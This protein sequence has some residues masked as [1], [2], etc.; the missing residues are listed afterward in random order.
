MI[1]SEFVRS[2]FPA[3]QNDFVFMDNAGGA[4][5]PRQVIERITEYLSHYNVQ[6]GASYEVSAVSGQK[7][8]AVTQG[9][10]K[11]INA[12]RQEE[13]VVGPSTTLLLRILS[14]CLSRQWK[15]GDEVIVT[16]SDHEANV[17][18]WTDL[19]EQG[20]IIKIW[21]LNPDTLTFELDDL[22]KLIT[23]RTRLV[24]MVHASNILGTINPIREFADF[25]HE[26]GAL[27]CVDGVAYA[28]HRQID[29][30]AL[31]VDFYVY[32]CYK[33]FG[34]H[35][36]V[37]YGRYELLRGLDGLNHYFIGKDQVPYKLQPGNFN[38]ELTYGLQGTLDY[39]DALQ[40]H[41]FPGVAEDQFSKVFELIAAHE[42]ILAE[43]LISYLRTLPAV[44]IIGME[45]SNR[46]TRVATISFVHANLKSSDI[47]KKVDPH[48]IGIRYGDFYAKKLIHDLGLD[49]DEG[50]VRVSLVHYNTLQ[51]VEQLIQ[52]FREIL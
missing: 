43:H 2:Q 17:S 40:K 12:S 16:N 18:C 21:K 37:L 32:S 33:V 35:L 51:E 36:A 20:I 5:V 10:A 41:H 15:P 7:L 11:L 1:D 50:V 30:Q 39:L 28:P 23:T 19:K 14:I 13:I 44:R 34:P 45:N 8:K 47:V 9:L 22:K 3:L 6:Q 42:E 24:A 31:H 48:R 46:N 38:F 52:V 49:L 29:V 25:V 4:Q 26:K 27:F